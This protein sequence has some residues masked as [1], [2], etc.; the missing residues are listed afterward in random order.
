MY[1]FQKRIY[2]TIL[3]SNTHDGTLPREGENSEEI[4]P[5]PDTVYWVSTTMVSTGGGWTAGN[6]AQRGF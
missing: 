2:E 6:A 1:L 4:V 5:F 3:N